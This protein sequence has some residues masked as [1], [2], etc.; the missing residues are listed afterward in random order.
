MSLYQITTYTSYT[1]FDDTISEDK[2][3]DSTL[4]SVGIYFK[5]VKGVLF[6]PP[7]LLFIHHVKSTKLTHVRSFHIDWE[8]PSRALLFDSRCRL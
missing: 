5:K 4:K 1:T 2:I 6:I 8:A 3:Y 7:H